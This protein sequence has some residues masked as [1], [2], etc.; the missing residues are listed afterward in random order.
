MDQLQAMRVFVQIADSGSLA[1][2][3]RQLGISPPSVARHL[4]DLESHLAV[5]LCQRT[6]R[7]LALTPEGLDYLETCRLCLRELAAAQVRLRSGNDEVQGPLT[8]AAPVLLGQMLVS[9][10]T[11]TFVRAH[12]GVRCKLVF[13][14]QL[15]DLVEQS[16]DVAVR[17]D[18]LPDSRLVSRRVGRVSRVVV[19]TPSYLAAH[20]EPQTPAD[21][22]GHACISTGRPWLFKVR[23]RDVQVPV[24]G[25]LEFNLGPPAL[26]ACLAG[27]GLG[28]FLS[29]QVK[30]AVRDG[31]L[32]PVLQK[33]ARSPMD[34]NIVTLQASAAP[35]R[36]RRFVDHLRRHLCQALLL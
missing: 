26:D 25:P 13:S 22:A 28:M 33:Y 30:S 12:P 23:G 16:I 9:P 10:I 20:G 24:Q 21:L 8:I 7:R 6:T 5:R 35:E 11:Q 34:V 29:Y 17:I 32:Q 4:A 1:G 18:N 27:M 15:T 19:G 2:A 14:D 36:T 3:A 31:L